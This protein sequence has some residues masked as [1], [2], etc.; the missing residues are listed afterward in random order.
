M[1]SLKLLRPRRWRFF[2]LSLLSTF[3]LPLSLAVIGRGKAAASLLLL[4][5]Q[6]RRMTIGALHSFSFAACFT[7]GPATR[8]RRDRLTKSCRRTCPTLLPFT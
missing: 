6:L 1:A 2:W 7:C 8:R 3:R 5:L 4:L